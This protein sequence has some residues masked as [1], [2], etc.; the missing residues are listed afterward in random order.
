[1]TTTNAGKDV[2]KQ[3]LSF[4]SGGNAKRY[5][6]SEDNLALSSKAKHNLTL[7]SSNC[8]FTQISW[9]HVHTETCT[10]MF[11]AALVIITENWKQPKCPSIDEW[12]NCHTSMQGNIIQ[13]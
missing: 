2:K 3:Q 11:I 6:T 9:K 5:D 13:W 10:Q 7:W 8:D 4:I 12:I 1:M